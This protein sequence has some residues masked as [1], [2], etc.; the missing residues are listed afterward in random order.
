MTNEDIINDIKN[1]LK[2]NLKKEHYESY[3]KQYDFELNCFSLN[4]T[5]ILHNINLFLE[6]KYQIEP[7]VS[8]V[9]VNQCFV[10][11]YPFYADEV[12]INFEYENNKLGIPKQSNKKFSFTVEQILNRED[13]FSFDFKLH[14]EY[15][16]YIRTPNYP[17]K[18]F[19]HGVSFQHTITEYAMNN[20]QSYHNNHMHDLYKRTEELKI[21]TQLFDFVNGSK[22]NVRDFFDAKNH[23]TLTDIVSVFQS[24]NF[25]EKAEVLQLTEDSS[26]L[27]NVNK[28]IEEIKNQEIFEKCRQDFL[29][30]KYFK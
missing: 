10:L 27:L 21:M 4:F 1:I 17:P 14:D 28:K 20:L 29:I 30:N 18:K 6:G 15:K 11:N 3:I 12:Y 13:S 24:K 8:T 2:I 9:I 19:D 5:N 23:Y 26:L 22:L 16:I 25:I 7:Q